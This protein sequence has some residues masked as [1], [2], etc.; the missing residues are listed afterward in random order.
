MNPVTIARELGATG[1]LLASYSLGYLTR[2]NWPLPATNWREPVILTHGLGGSRTNLLGM[3]ALAGMAG[4]GAIS[5]F[6]YP[7]RQSL[8]DSAAQLAAMAAHADRGAGVHLIGHSLGGTIARMASARLSAGA[9]RSLITLAAPYSH[10]QR[11][12]AE[13]AFFGDE[14]PII[15]PPT[16]ER[17][18]EGAFKRI[19]IL[20]NTGHLGVLYHW[21]VMHLTFAE[22]RANRAVGG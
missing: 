2:Y 1:A 18:A 11:S 12:P 16:R 5:Y 19:V 10:A 22:L 3:A 15:R 21:E 8:E 20:P 6:E 13:F 4:F 17:L 14:D 9:I 7:V